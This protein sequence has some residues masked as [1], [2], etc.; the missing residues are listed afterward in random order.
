MRILKK[1]FLVKKL[2]NSL[3]ML[4]RHF[5]QKNKTN[6]ELRL[7]KM[8][9][10]YSEKNPQYLNLKN[11]LVPSLIIISTFSIYKLNKQKKK[12]LE[13][14]LN[15]SKKSFKEHPESLIL[16]AFNMNNR[17][18]FLI[19]FPGICFSL[20][21]L[22]NKLSHKHFLGFF[23]LNLISS[24][25]CTYYYQTTHTLVNKNMIIPINNGSTTSLFFINFFAAQ[26][27]H[28]Q[29]FNCRFLPFFFYPIFLMFY[30]FYDWKFNYVR[31]INKP[32]HFLSIFNGLVM[33]FFFRRYQLIR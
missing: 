6:F 18:Q 31:E 4:K 3:K 11:M 1:E 25:G 26:N 12:D 19:Y 30:E 8:E 16:S 29:F 22:S 15:I 21:S 14:S 32:S 33:G 17:E 9:K 20:I 10:E 2:K 28:Y 23:L 27:P 24:I 13:N 7:E 5:S